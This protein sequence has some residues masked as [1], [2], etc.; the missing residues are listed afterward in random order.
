MQD[1]ET[2]PDARGGI[3]RKETEE[4]QKY[5]RTYERIEITVAEVSL[6]EAL[7]LNKDE[8]ELLERLQE[9]MRRRFDSG[10]EDET[11]NGG[12]ESASGK[13]STECTMVPTQSEGARSN[14][15]SSRSGR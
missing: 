2:L 10:R 4:E 5:G 8:A 15:E 7:S 9:R 14:S 12:T 11:F 1:I 3:E 6:P 13:S